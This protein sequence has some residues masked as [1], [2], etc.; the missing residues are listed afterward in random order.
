MNE[1]IWVCFVFWLKNFFSLSGVGVG[2]IHVRCDVDSNYEYDEFV[3]YIYRY[4]YIYTCDFLWPTQR[5]G[6]LCVNVCRMCVFVCNCVNLCG[7][8]CEYVSICVILCHIVSFCVYSCVYC[9]YLYVFP[10]PE[11]WGVYFHPRNWCTV[12]RPEWAIY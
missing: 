11:L 6:N 2:V 1:L 12:P 5:C 4:I 3:V 8:L 9:V 7:I 10:R